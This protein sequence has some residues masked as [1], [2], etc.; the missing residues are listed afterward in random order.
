MNGPKMRRGGE[1][2]IAQ[3]DAQGSLGT[4]W[5][6]MVLFNSG[7]I[8]PAAPP[9]KGR[10]QFGHSRRVFQA[11][12]DTPLPTFALRPEGALGT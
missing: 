7:N 6:P 3:G 11:K 10:M 8:P 2:I 9:L 4:G 1:W 12:K 5:K